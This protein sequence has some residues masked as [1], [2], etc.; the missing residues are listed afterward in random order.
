[1]DY[2]DIDTGRPIDR[3]ARGWHCVGLAD[4]FRDGRPHGLDAFGTRLVVFAEAGGELR[5]LDAYC[6]HMGADLS[7]GTIKDGA[8]ACPFHDWRWDGPTGRCTGVP[9]ARRV[10]RLARTRRWPTAERNGQLLIWHDP[11]GSEASTDLL[12][13]AIDGIESGAWTDW[14][15]NSERIEGS[16]CREI[17]DNT[18]DM[19][20]FF[21]IH[22]AYPT[23]FKNVLDGHC[24]SQFM[25]SKARPDVFGTG[26]HFSEDAH[27]RSEAT[28][29][30]PAYM[31]NLIHNHVAPDSVIEVA[32]INS[33]YPISSESFMLQW[34][35]AVQ[36][37]PGLTEEQNDRM[38][39]AFSQN[40]SRGFLE[41]IEV[42][43]SKTRIENPLLTEE[44][45]PVY[46]L[47]RWYRQFYVDVGDV[48]PEMTARYEYE[49]DT[50]RANDV[51]Q[52]EVA[53]NLAAQNAR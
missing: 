43:R 8:I 36:K 47:R 7:G 34:G 46:Q 4:T 12:P 6:R 38:A 1:M 52:A 49:I 27:L 44:D 41:D 50:A 14:V 40:F 10:P 13:P 37:L 32:L 35:I 18:V 15:W 2:R 19:A 30:G 31:V 22:H 53:R 20:H 25:H 23:Y 21:Y 3:Y 26:K 48:S 17:I 42:W 28:Y 9:Y 5:A 51:W 45:G 16:H 33:H 24:A 11:E 39:R 29:F